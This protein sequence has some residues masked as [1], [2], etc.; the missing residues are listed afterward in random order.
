M[1]KLIIV[2]ITIISI[3]SI[4]VNVSAATVT[5]IGENGA[6][7]SIK[8]LVLEDLYYSGNVEIR[9]VVFKFDH[10]DNIW[11]EGELNFIASLQAQ[12]FAQAL[13]DEVSELYFD[14][15]LQ[16][17]ADDDWTYGGRNYCYIP[18]DIDDTNNTMSAWQVGNTSS[19]GFFIM[20]R[21]SVDLSD[22]SFFHGIMF[23][24]SKMP[25]EVPIPGTFL[26]FG[27]SIMAFSAIRKKRAFRK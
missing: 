1:K 23:A 4:S 20:E 26:L 5:R 15:D 27:S 13:Y 10:W 11:D 8:G 9:D 22:S 18:Y 24:E 19:G 12:I 7:Q 6:V 21:E 16:I 25:S 17:F 14:D 3:Y 2:L